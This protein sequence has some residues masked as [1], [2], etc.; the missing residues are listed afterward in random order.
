MA[1][2]FNLYRVTGDWYARIVRPI[3][4][5]IAN[6]TTGVLSTAT[7]WGDSAMALTFGIVLGGYPLTMP[8][9]LPAGE[10]DVIFYNAASGAASNADVPALGKRVEW[11]GSQ[12][13]GLPLEL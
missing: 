5:K 10:Y 4:D 9:A 3:D 1:T 11:T 13:L 12:I 7:A 6:A 8:S 2:K